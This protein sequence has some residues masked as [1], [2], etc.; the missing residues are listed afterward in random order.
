M[1]STDQQFVALFDQW[2]FDLAW[3]P[4]SAYLV[5]G[6]V[7]DVLR[8]RSPTY[9]D[10]DFVLPS[11]AVETAQAIAEHYEAGFVLLDAERHIARVVFPSATADFAQ[12]MGD[13]LTDD[14]QRRDFTVNAIASN[15]HTQELVD[16]TG[17]LQ[18]IQQGVMRMIAPQNFQDDPLRL[19]R[20]YR[21][22]AQL[23]FELDPT[24]QNAIRQ[25]AP[26]L[27][28]IS[29]ERVRVELGYLLSHAQGTPW[30]QQL[31]QD[32][33]LASW[34]PHAA[35]LD[36]IAAVDS[37]VKKLEIAWPEMIPLLLQPLNDRAQGSE[38]AQRTLLSLVKLLGLLAPDV[39]TAKQTLS[40][41]KYAR[42]EMS[43]VLSLLQS[44]NTLSQRSMHQ[45]SRREQ[46]F[47]FQQ[48]GSAFPALVVWLMAVGHSLEEM[49]PFI[50]AYFDP[51][52]LVAH[53]QPLV[54]GKTLMTALGLKSG[55]QIGELLTAL[56]LA[57]ADGKIE[58]SKEALVL[59]QIWQ[60]EGRC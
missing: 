53:P 9:L 58:T 28:Q 33:L 8:G 40:N 37:A 1:S 24:T 11:N 6:Y 38:A 49:H 46:Y 45:L 50:E 12:Q 5:G 7:R 34:L 52:S 19:M 29:A 18:D 59:A 22:A 57:Q 10:L 31:W 23:G 35:G 42:A 16:P 47:L 48:V 43:L 55:P 14:L 27:Q 56:E 39:K 32:Q 60:S 15:P 20:A 26:L 4:D 54:S 30:L 41:L 17:G 36:Q 44:C 2:P 3:I 13:T 51:E 21:Q 25:F